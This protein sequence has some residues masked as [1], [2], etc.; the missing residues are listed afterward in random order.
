M[1]CVLEQWGGGADCVTL[2]WLQ[3]ANTATQYICRSSSA[4]IL[5]TL[6]TRSPCRA[7]LH[8]RSH[9]ILL[10]LSLQRRDLG[11]LEADQLLELLDL[12]L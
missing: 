8:S 1:H 10:Q 3:V 12:D 5:R 9:F 6:P 7:R 2:L 4:L 11:V